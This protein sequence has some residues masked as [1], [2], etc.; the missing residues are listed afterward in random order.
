[1]CFFSGSSR[2]SDSAANYASDEG[3]R[4]G[5]QAVVDDE[6]DEVA[7]SHSLFHV[8]MAVACLFVMMTLTHWDRY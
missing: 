4:E 2:N 8:A 5:G 6:E 7:Y 3:D 1:M